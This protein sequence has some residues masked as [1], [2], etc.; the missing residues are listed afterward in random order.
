MSE[1]SSSVSRHG[2]SC[3]EKKKFLLPAH[4]YS[5]SD[6]GVDRLGQTPGGHNFCEPGVTGITGIEF[7]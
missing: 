6:H 1:W 3:E 2:S 4:D 7:S 5:C